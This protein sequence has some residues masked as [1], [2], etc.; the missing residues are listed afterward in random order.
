MSESQDLAELEQ[1][2]AKDPTGPAFVALSSE[3]T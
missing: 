3:S 1:A 2:F